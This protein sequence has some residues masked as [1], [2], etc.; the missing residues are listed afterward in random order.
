MENPPVSSQTNVNS[1]VSAFWKV[2]IAVVA[3]AVIA[4]VGTYYL[5]S[6]QANAQKDDLNSQITTLQ[7]QVDDLKKADSADS[8]AAIDDT[9]IADWKTY[10]DSD[11]KISFKYPADWFVFKSIRD[12]RIYVENVE[13]TSDDQWN[14]SNSPSNFQRVWISY[15]QNESSQENENNAKSATNYNLQGKQITATASTIDANDIIINTYEFTNT[16]N[17]TLKAF[18]ADTSD[19]RYSANMS[20]ENGQTNQENEIVVL[21][22]LLS[23]FQFTK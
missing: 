11:L 8:T 12:E 4:G 10:T 5:V 15:S 9:A 14:K 19:K 6:I 20:T 23:T 22:N 16:S 17:P 7:K 1:G 18:W 3:S 21:K 2:L 13:Q